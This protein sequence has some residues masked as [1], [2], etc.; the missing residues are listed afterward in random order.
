MTGR[1]LIIYIM[2]NGL[3]DRPVFEN[4]TLLG[5]MTEQQFAEKMSV[6]IATVEV[7]IDL[8]YLSDVIRVGDMTFI[9]MNYSEWYPL[10]ALKH[11]YKRSE[12]NE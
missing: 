3:E 8:G 12:D 10:H 7:W 2:K 5:F 11:Q 4:D 6:G 9:P 1:D